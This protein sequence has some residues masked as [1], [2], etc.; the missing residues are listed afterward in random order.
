MVHRIELNPNGL[1]FALQ[2]LQA[3]GVLLGKSISATMAAGNV[4]WIR[5]AN[6]VG[7]STLLRTLAGGLSGQSLLF[8]AP[9]GL[10]PEMTV[11]QHLSAS[12]AALGQVDVP[13]DPLLHRVGL[14]DWAEERIQTLSSGQQARL[15]LAVFAAA[16]KPVWLLDEPLNA[17][18]QAGLKIL[19]ELVLA[20]ARQG[21]V[22]VLASHQAID[23][24][25]GTESGAKPVMWQLEK[26]RL[27]R[28]SDDSDSEA[29]PIKWLPPSLSSWGAFR[30]CWHREWLLLKA[31]PQQLGW[32]ALF[33]WLVISFFGIAVLRSDS[34]FALAVVWVSAI[35]AILLTAKDWFSEDQRTGWLSFLQHSSAF[36]TD[37]YWLARC[38][39]GVLTQS[40]ST[41]P[42]VVLA[43]LQFALPVTQVLWL[44]FA[45]LFGILAIS[46]LMGLI[47]LLVMMTR[48]GAVLV[49]LLALPL[50]VPVLV[51][52]LEASQA[53]ALGRS[54]APAFAVLACLAALGF[55]VAPPVAR[56]LIAMIQE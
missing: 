48:G 15:A 28:G 51:F 27:K 25:Y 14:T 50:L 24:L 45:L 4:H 20:H 56:R 29:L 3:G 7:K 2:A 13:I 42:V 30:M 31:N 34:P 52:G 55:M 46:P 26:G 1:D 22:V 19:G 6:G 36:G 16:Q 43:G 8:K 12:L 41:M 54:P 38:T 10:R 21:G 17:L 18:D 33:H 5:G 53:F 32:T 44:E 9:F 47:S 11:S 35:L 23:E 39:S 37:K 40:A 49:Y